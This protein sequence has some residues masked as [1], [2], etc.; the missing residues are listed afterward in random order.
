MQ[1][2]GL[3]YSSNQLIINKVFCFCSLTH[4]LSF[5]KR[6][7]L[8]Q[9]MLTILFYMFTTHNQVFI[10]NNASSNVVFLSCENSASTFKSVF[11]YL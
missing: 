7:L 5:F 6:K 3:T 10:D 1:I 11:S 2:A 4:S 8:T 9:K